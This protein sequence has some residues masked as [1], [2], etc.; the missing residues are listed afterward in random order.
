MTQEPSRS[1]LLLQYLIAFTIALWCSLFTS[2]WNVPETLP[3]TISP[4]STS[5]QSN[6]LFN[7]H[8][9]SLTFTSTLMIFYK[10]VQ[11]S[12]TNCTWMFLV[13]YGKQENSFCSCPCD[14]VSLKKEQIGLQ[15]ITSAYGDVMLWWFKLCF[16]HISQLTKTNPTKNKEQKPKQQKKKPCKINSTHCYCRY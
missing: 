15:Q 12:Q 1:T 2:V 10:H 9:G 6:L 13:W 4:S 3:A 8:K 16:V 14:L 11:S 5:L 7:L